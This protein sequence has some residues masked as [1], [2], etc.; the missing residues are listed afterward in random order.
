MKILVVAPWVPGKIRPRSLRFVEYLARRHELRFVVGVSSAEDRDALSNLEKLG[1]AVPVPLSRAGGIWRSFRALFTATSLQQAYVN[2]PRFETMLSAELV[3]FAPDVCYFNVIRTGHLLPL[4]RST[5]ILLDLDETRSEYYR[6]QRRHGRTLV[7]RLIGLLEYGR[8]K[9]AEEQAISLADVIV[10]SSPAD[11]GFGAGKPFHLVRTGLELDR[12]T[13]VGSS[14]GQEELVF[15]GRLDYAANAD[16]II[17][18]TKNVLPRLAAVRPNVQLRIIGS[19]PT[20]KVRRLTSDRVRVTADVPEL[21]LFLSQAACVI[22]PI[23]SATGVQMKLLEGLA[24]GTPVICTPKVAAGA[25]VVD[26]R[27]VLV[28][29]TADE[30]LSAV[31]RL[32]DG[33]A[34]RADLAVRGRAW[35]LQHHDADVVG[36]EMEFLVNAARAAGRERK[37]PSMPRRSVQEP[38]RHRLSTRNRAGY[39]ELVGSGEP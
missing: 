39:N 12:E 27:E 17:W 20:R 2:S 38:G 1:S 13:A 32:L 36:A 14:C 25:E 30:W 19:A 15:A 35:L 10:V 22:A 31:V 37:K 5:G 3:S 34:L 18:F 8:M 28:A 21:G 11:V 4:A 29:E 23:S 33:A 26:G 9:R 16:G 24:A 6:Q 7:G